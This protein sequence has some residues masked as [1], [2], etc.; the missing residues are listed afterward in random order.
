MIPRG[1]WIA[2]LPAALFAACAAQAEILALRCPMASIAAE[3]LYEIDLAKKVVRLTNAVTTISEAATVDERF[4]TWRSANASFRLDRSSRELM[5]A[6]SAD[7]PW[8][9]TSFCVPM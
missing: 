6:S 3:N 9:I 1:A 2:A 8:E 4:V 5:Q 7:G